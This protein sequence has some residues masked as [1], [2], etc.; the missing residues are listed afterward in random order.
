MGAM[1]S[2]IGV[3][4][5]AALAAGIWQHRR[6]LGARRDIVMDRQPMIYPTAS[7]H[8]VMFLKVAAGKDVIDEVRELRGLIETSSSGQMIYAGQVGTAMVTSY[9][10]RSWH[11]ASAISCG[12]NPPRIP[13]NPRAKMPSLSRKRK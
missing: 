5:I 13:S 1:A 6:Y 3:L 4:G 9:P 8:A 7:F 10:R 12:E 2:G 11:C